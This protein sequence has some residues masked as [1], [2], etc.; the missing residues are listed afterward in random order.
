MNLNE[1]KNRYASFRDYIVYKKTIKNKIE[2]DIKRIENEIDNLKI[3]EDTF[4]KA[5]ILLEESSMY[6]R[7]QIKYQ[8]EVMVT[9]A[10]QF[11]TGENIEFKIEFEQKRGRPEASFYVVTKLDDDSEV[12]N[13]PEESRGGGIIDIISLTLKYCMLQTHNPP[14]EGPFIL[15]EPAKHVSEEYIV[16]VGKFLKEINTAF[17]RQI[18]MV[19]HNTHLSEIS[20]K[21]YLV[22]MENGI[23]NATEYNIE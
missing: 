19:T 1:I 20:D 5:K 17:N 22:T 16:N 13:N 2:E 9:K 10:L 18:I 6:A 23:S 7:E 12:K 11:V 21:R 4:T 8:F 3:Q 15:D 14:I